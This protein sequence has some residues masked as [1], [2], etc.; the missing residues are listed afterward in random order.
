M[1]ARL[2]SAAAPRLQSLS[3][4]QDLHRLVA[5]PIFSRQQRG[6]LVAHAR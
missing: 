3:D 2:V 5:H 1:V 4:A 6:G